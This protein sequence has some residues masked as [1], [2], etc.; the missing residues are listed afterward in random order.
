MTDA[1]LHILGI[2]GS[3]RAGS[4]NRGLLR[5]AVALI[6][7]GATLDTF[8]LAGLPLYN[9]DLESNVP[10]E[11]KGLRAAIRAADAVLLVTPEYNYSVSGVLKNAIDWGSR[12]PKENTWDGKPGAIMGASPGLLGT[13]RAQ[14]HLRQ[15]LQS[16]NVLTLNHPEVMVASAKTK[17]DTEGNLLDADT[18]ERVKRLLEALVAWTRRL[19]P[20]AHRT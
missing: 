19:K 8:E 6:P 9:F 15:V 2:A 18:R 1:T 7:Q 3:L 10:S 13:A 5:A 20:A 16:V 4:F 17:F 11:A 14:Y 12:P